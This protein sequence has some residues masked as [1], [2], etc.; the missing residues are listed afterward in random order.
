M[1]LGIAPYVYLV[2]LCLQCM[3]GSWFCFC[4]YE[5]L[6]GNTVFLW[7]LG[8]KSWWICIFSEWCSRT[9]SNCLEPTVLSFGFFPLPNILPSI[10][11]CGVEVMCWCATFHAHLPSLSG[12]FLNAIP[13]SSA[14][15]YPPEPTVMWEHGDF[16][17]CNFFNLTLK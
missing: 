16:T 10:Y 5:N 4:S 12:V 8:P 11:S 13:A 7:S 3:E 1:R 6:G 14:S 9:L 15:P 17:I 2:L